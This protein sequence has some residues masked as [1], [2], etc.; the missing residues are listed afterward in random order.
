MHVEKASQPGTESAPGLEAMIKEEGQNMT[1]LQGQR[2]MEAGEAT[3][4]YGLL[5]WDM[6][7][8]LCVP[9]DYH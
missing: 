6:A 4:G 3:T 2:S 9:T 8:V 5:G 7:L 1:L